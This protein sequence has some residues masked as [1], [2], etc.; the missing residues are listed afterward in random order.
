[1]ATESPAA[2]WMSGG[3]LV[4]S[5]FALGWNVYR[6]AI[7]RGKLRVSCSVSQIA[8]VG[9]GVI[10]PNVLAWSVTNVGR[11]P[12]LVTQIGG[13]NARSKGSWLVLSPKG[14]ALPK[15]LQPGE[16]YSGYT[17]DFRLIGPD[18]DKLWAV[19]SLSRRFFAPKRQVAE[20]IRAVTDKRA[21][22]EVGERARPT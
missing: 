19:D 11:Q 18:L 21:R 1:M 6:D 7:D 5:G 3:S 16:Y 4:I 2:L 22:G 13:R 10:E 15:M 17:A 8:Q 9:V 20:V 12:V 14:E